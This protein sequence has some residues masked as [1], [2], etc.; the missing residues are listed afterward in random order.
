MTT[1]ILTTPRELADRSDRRTGPALAELPAHKPQ[2]GRGIVGPLVV[3]FDG[4]PAAKDA[5][6]LSALLGR[7]TG[8]ELLVACVS[9]PPSLAGLPFEPRATRV[10]AGDHRIFVRQDAYAVLAEARAALPEDLAVTFRALECES[11][12][13]ALRQLALSAAADMLILGWTHHGPIGPLLHRG[14]ARGLLRHPPCAI[15][16]TPHDPYE[17]RQSARSTHGGL[18]IPAGSEQ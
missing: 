15:A 8:C 10:A 16:V 7:S 17:R 5:L 1:D 4:S 2:H 13:H 18:R 14:V 6:R 12:V 9:P 11:P 3:A